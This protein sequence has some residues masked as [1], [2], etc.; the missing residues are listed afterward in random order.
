MAKKLTVAELETLMITTISECGALSA[1]LDR[2]HDWCVKAQAKITALEEQDTK[3]RK[4]LWYLQKVAKG[5]FAIGSKKP[6]NGDA[7]QEEAHDAMQL[8][9]AE[10]QPF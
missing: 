7:Q 9:L 8:S 10:N 3:T 1:R 5:E 2:A 4:Q 6:T